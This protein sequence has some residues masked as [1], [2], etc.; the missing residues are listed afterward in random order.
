MAIV[1]CG[2]SCSTSWEYDYPDGDWFYGIFANIVTNS[3]TIIPNYS[4]VTSDSMFASFCHKIEVSKELDWG[5]DAYYQFAFFE[6][7]EVNPSTYKFTRKNVS[8]K[9][10]IT[11]TYNEGPDTWTLTASSSHV[12]WTYAGDLYQQTVTY[13]DG[14]WTPLIQMQFKSQSVEAASGEYLGLIITGAEYYS[15]WAAPNGYWA[16]NTI[17]VKAYDGT[18][19]YYWK[20]DNYTLQTDDVDYGYHSGVPII[21]A[22]GTSGAVV[23]ACQSHSGKYYTGNTINGWGSV[24]ISSISSNPYKA[25]TN[26]ITPWGESLT[27]EVFYDGVTRTFDKDGGMEHWSLKLEITCF[28]GW[29]C[30]VYNPYECWWS[31]KSVYYVKTTGNDSSFGGSWATAFKTITKGAQTVP[32]GGQLFIEEGTYNNETQIQP[33]VDNASYIIQPTSHTEAACTVTVNLA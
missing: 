14:H 17:H 2:V 29:G 28:T 3:F 12:W 21:Y 11:K 20:N 7:E 24:Y 23:D 33:T 27:S 9:I 5:L 26:I 30:W 25:M 22:V 16:E 18:I 19:T 6:K 10:K 13:P 8:E 15:G 32:D 1:D 31:D 4:P